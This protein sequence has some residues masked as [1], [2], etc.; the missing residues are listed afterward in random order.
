MIR[1]MDMK[2]P[3][4]TIRS[5]V[6]TMFLLITEPATD[7]MATMVSNPTTTVEP[8]ELADTPT[9]GPI[10]NMEPVDTDI[11]VTPTLD[12]LA[13]ATVDTQPAMEDTQPAME[14]TVQVMVLDPTQQSMD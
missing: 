9:M 7:L 8:M 13:L 12:T 2:K 6:T 3:I 10:I 14:D 11:M 1:E 4:T 5:V